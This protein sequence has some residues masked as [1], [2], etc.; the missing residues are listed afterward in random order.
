VTRTASSSASQSSDSPSYDWVD[1]LVLKIPTRIMSVDSDNGGHLWCDR[2]CMPRSGKCTVR[3]LF[4]VYNTFFA[5]LHITLPFDNFT[6]GVL[7]ILNVAPTQLHPNSWA[8]LQAFRLLC[9]NFK[10][11]PTPE[12]FL[13]YYN[14]RLSTLVSWLS[15]SSR[16]ENIWF[17]A[18]TTSYKN[19]KEKYFKI[20]VEPDG[21]DLF[22]NVNGTTKFPFHWTEKPTQLDNW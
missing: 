9:Q 3:L 7:R 20:F 10:L 15:L 8:T 19:F 17:A 4:F 5:N 2:S 22:Y 12:S 11:E 18:F 16:P 21:R 6:M 13:Y 14:T 1:P